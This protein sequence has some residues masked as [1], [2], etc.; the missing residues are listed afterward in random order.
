MWD[1]YCIIGI[2]AVSLIYFSDFGHCKRSNISFEHLCR[3]LVTKLSP[4][5]LPL[6]PDLFWHHVRHQTPQN[7]STKL[8]ERQR[9]K[10]WEKMRLVPKCK[11]KQDLIADRRKARTLSKTAALVQILVVSSN[12]REARW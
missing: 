4:K 10:T 7:L 5:R 6:N 12:S 8:Q 1:I 11:C 2:L 3:H 9:P